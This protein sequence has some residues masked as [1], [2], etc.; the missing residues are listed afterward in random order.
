MFNNWLFP[1]SVY[2]VIFHSNANETTSPFPQQADHS[3]LFR[4]CRIL[5]TGAD[6][7]LAKRVVK[8]FELYMLVV[9]I[10]Q[11]N[12]YK[13]SETSANGLKSV[14]Y[15]FL[16]VAVMNLLLWASDS[17]FDANSYDKKIIEIVYDETAEKFISHFLFPFLVFFRFK[18]FITFYGIYNLQPVEHTYLAYAAL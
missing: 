1:S 12:N 14:K 9:C 7:L 5:C 6:L 4:V 17:L 13:F 8:V 3:K 15:V 16:V 18:T 10:L 11:F 2:A